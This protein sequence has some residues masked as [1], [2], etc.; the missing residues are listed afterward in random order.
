M[1]I[2]DAI[3]EFAHD[4]A[5]KYG[6]QLALN[7]LRRRRRIL[8]QICRFAINLEA[9]KKAS[10]ELEALKLVILTIEAYNDSD[11]PEPRTIQ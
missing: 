8:Y 1:N 5:K 2:P 7:A 3:Q 4:H 6:K 10:L 11:F 9:I